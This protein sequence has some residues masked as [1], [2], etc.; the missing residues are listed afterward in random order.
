MSCSS[1]LF[2]VC[3][4][5]HWF[6]DTLFSLLTKVD[7]VVSLCVYILHYTRFMQN[8]LL[9][10]FEFSV[11]SSESLKYRVC[12]C[13]NCAQFVVETLIHSTFL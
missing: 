4:A 2:D 10:V 6:M 7:F 13:V 3:S 1:L 5:A 9:I 11:S 8:S 12:V